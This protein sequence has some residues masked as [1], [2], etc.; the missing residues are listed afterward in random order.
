M[1]LESIQNIERYKEESTFS[2]ESVKKA[3]DFII[4]K[5]DQSLDTFTDKFPAA[6][7][8]NLVY[9][10]IDNTCWTASFWTGM[11]W[12]AYEY[13]GENKYKDVAMKQVKSF[14]ERLNHEDLINTHDI[15]FLYTL[16]CVAAY[17]ITGDEFA[18]ETALLAADKLMK[19]Y[20]P[21]AGIIQAWGD[22]S[23]PE[24]Q[25]RLI[26]D[27]CMNLPLLYWA[28]EITGD[29][30]YKDAAVSHVKQ[31][32][33]YIVREDSS[34]Y[35]TF[36]MDVKTGAPRFGSTCQGFSDDSC[37]ARGQAW[38]IYGFPLSFGYTKDRDILNLTSHVANYFLNRLPDDDISYWDLS[39]SG[40]NINRDSSSSA[41]AACGLLEYCRFLDNDKN[42][43]KIYKNASISMLKNLTDKC[44]TVT[45][46]ES[47][48]LLLHAV[49][50]MPKNVGVDE[51]NIWGDYFYFEG[52]MRLN[53][54]WKKYW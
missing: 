2:G 4:S 14:R 43:Q 28:S 52:L 47:N 1:I 27:C 37:W 3:L 44:A 53:R 49:Y 38:A 40:D 17:K 32:A 5:I 8:I 22:L 23:D 16:S 30:K 21:I 46:P 20:F 54:D 48:G 11:L 42:L 6:S 34:T 18:K 31:A 25:G 33:K 41:I 7:S 12:L 15:G 29:N 36:Y 26:I 24:Q 39:L 19:R 51:C 13:T 50:D 10:A 35:H 9:P 45:H